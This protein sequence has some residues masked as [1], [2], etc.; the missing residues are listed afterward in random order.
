MVTI[1]WS[2]YCPCP[3]RDDEDNRSMTLPYFI[4]TIEPGTRDLGPSR[5]W[6]VVPSPQSTLDH[7]KCFHWLRH[8][9][10]PI[11]QR[12]ECVSTTLTHILHGS[13]V[14]YGHYQ[15]LLIYLPRSSLCGSLQLE[16][17][18]G[19]RAITQWFEQLVQV[20]EKNPPSTFYSTVPLFIAKNTAKWSMGTWYQL[21]APCA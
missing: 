4:L 20:D 21:A 8:S 6:I 5:G 10:M 19:R 12:E 9:W 14:R 18:R 3:A 2:S 11:V 15:W 16:G 7:D 13:I 1:Q 17:E